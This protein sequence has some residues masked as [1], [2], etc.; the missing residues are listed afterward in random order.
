MKEESTGKF[1]SVLASYHQRMEEEEALMRSLAPPEG[2]KRRDE[3]L[4]AVGLDAARFLHTMVRTA[5]ARTILEVG[6]SYGYSTLWLADAARATGGKVIT[7]ELDPRKANYAREQISA[8]GLTEVVEFRIGDAQESIRQ[9]RETFDLVLLD[10]WKDLYVPCFELFFPKLSPGA[11][12]IADNMVHPPTHRAEAAAYR[13]AVRKTNAFNTILLP[14]GSG[15]EVSQI[16][17]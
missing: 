10:I 4:L 14:I 1:E 12:V 11:Y 9:A 15:L 8:A 3:F 7:L 6:T 2:M 13:Q 5:E 17:E 16:K